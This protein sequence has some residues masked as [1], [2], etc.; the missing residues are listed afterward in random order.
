MAKGKLVGVCV[1][2]VVVAAAVGGLF[3]ISIIYCL[4]VAGK[5][6][7]LSLQLG[8][9]GKLATIVFMFMT[10]TSTDKKTAQDIVHN[11]SLFCSIAQCSAI[12]FNI[13]VQSNI[14]CTNDFTTFKQSQNKFK[15]VSKQLGQLYCNWL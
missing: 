13:T 2:Y 3:Y 15:T 7:F 9:L 4:M 10:T 11:N 8:K 5:Y 14:Q 1:L 12:N 6:L